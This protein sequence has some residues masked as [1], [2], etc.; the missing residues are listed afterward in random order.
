M[1]DRYLL[2]LDIDEAPLQDIRASGRRLVI[3]KHRPGCLPE[4]IW[5]T[6]EPTGCDIIAWH[7]TYGLYAAA[8][9]LAAGGAIAVDCALERTVD[10]AIYPYSGRAFGAPYYDQHVLRGHYDV[11]NRS[12][13][14]AT[15]GLLQAARVN[16]R[17]FRFPVNAVA[18][19]A[20]WTADFT[21]LTALSVWVQ[22]D[23]ESG[24]VAALPALWTTIVFTA[25]RRTA[26][27]RYDVLESRLV[28]SQSTRNRAKE[29][30]F[31]D[32]TS[33]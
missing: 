6:V 27:Y 26:R 22:A 10:R 20:D 33:H 28:P 17:I 9:G 31:E 11:H 25:D 14:V 18:V 3:A 30:G 8:P 12:H 21:A 23:V 16:G 32:T 4:I 5:L 7:E 2:S 15:L 29:H 13:A 1:P 24:S 19:P